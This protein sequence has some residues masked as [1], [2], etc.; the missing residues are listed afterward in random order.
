[1]ILKFLIYCLIYKVYKSQN[2][3]LL[4]KNVDLKIQEEKNEAKE[5]ADRIEREREEDRLK[6]Q[7][8][9]EEQFRQNKGFSY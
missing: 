6:Y 3:I 2:S 7:S 8:I 5:R 4:R 9:Q 1:M